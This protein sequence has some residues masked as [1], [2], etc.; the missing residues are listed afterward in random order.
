MVDIARKV[1]KKFVVDLVSC[2]VNAHHHLEDLSIIYYPLIYPDFRKG[3]IEPSGGYVEI[4]ITHSSHETARNDETAILLAK[5]GFKVRL[6]PVDEVPNKKNPDAYLINEDIIIEFKHNFTPTASAIKNEVRDAKKQADYI[7]LHI[8]S[9]LTKG[10]LLRGL[11][12]TI[13]RAKNIQEVWII[14]NHSIYRLTP[15]EILN[16][17]ASRKIQ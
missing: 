6:L 16:G 8:K 5:R 13:H 1:A 17:T 4:H 7:L 2:H 10:E 15:M 3:E 12:L 11:N 14:F 9:S